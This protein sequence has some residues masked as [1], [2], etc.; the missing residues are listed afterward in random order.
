MLVASSEKAR[1]SVPFAGVAQGKRDDTR[2]F[3]AQD[4]DGSPWCGAGNGEERTLPAAGR[5]R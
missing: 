3:R 4:C 5:L 1:D 2:Y